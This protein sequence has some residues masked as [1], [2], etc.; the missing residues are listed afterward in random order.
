MFGLPVETRP[1]DFSIVV[2]FGS[3]LMSSP[4]YIKLIK[5]VSTL[6]N[7]TDIL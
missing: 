1:S 2:Y 4:Q 7:I 5:W 6:G 3:E